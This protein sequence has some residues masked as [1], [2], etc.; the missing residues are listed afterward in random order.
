MFTAS[1][2][3]GK[4]DSLGKRPKD[5]G[6]GKEK[7]K[8]QMRSIKGRNQEKETPTPT[9]LPLLTQRLIRS[10]LTPLTVTFQLLL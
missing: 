1:L 5:T 6:R 4:I 10:P 7:R 3:R 9:C 2:R 8:E